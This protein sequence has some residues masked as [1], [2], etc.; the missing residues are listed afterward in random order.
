MCLYSLR[1]VRK[2]LKDRFFSVTSTRERA[3][4][5]S[6][7]PEVRRSRDSIDIRVTSALSSERDP[8]A[9][10]NFQSWGP[11]L[12]LR[13]ITGPRATPHFHL[14]IFRVRKFEGLPLT[15]L[16]CLPLVGNIIRMESP[17]Y[18]VRLTRLVG[19]CR[20]TRRSRR[21]TKTR[22]E[23]RVPSPDDDAIFI[24][25]PRRRS[26]RPRARL[27]ADRNPRVTFEFLDGSRP[28]DRK[29]GY[30]ARLS[31]SAHVPPRLSDTRF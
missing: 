18:S 13:L 20:F 26:L 6:L 30:L 24:V 8:F 2:T 19:Y 17:N 4:G 1:C 10:A 14:Q 16:P 27:A 9:R 11:F 21:F 3:P 12:V 7:V 15:L 25:H 23:A 29:R 22:E 5:N 28:T 31:L